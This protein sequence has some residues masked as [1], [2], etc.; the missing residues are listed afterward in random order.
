MLE[1]DHFSPVRLSSFTCSLV[2]ATWGPHTYHGQCTGALV[3]EVEILILELGAV[4]AL[5]SRAV[6]S[7]EVAR[8]RAAGE[9]ERVRECR[10]G[11][12]VC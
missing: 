9:A 10:W 12:F 8:L 11:C 4:D 1:T 5:P 7:R 3:L 2:H 6:A